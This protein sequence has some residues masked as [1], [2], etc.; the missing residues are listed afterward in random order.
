MTGVPA[1]FIGHGSP[2]NTLESNAYTLVWQKLGRLLPRPRGILVVSA[3]WFINA[4][5]VTAT[6]PNRGQV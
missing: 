1:L 3:H 2:M 4:T 5:A 6:P